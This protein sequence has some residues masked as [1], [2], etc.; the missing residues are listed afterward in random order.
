MLPHIFG[1]YYNI[2]GAIW[3]YFTR[4]TVNDTCLVEDFHDITS[5]L[6]VVL[7][8]VSFKYFSNCR[9]ICVC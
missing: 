8:R 5:L 2:N 4:R 6:K 3:E 7:F 1:V 9:K